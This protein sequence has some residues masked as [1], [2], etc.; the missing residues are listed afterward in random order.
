VTT[1]VREFVKFSMPSL[2]D[3]VAG[4]AQLFAYGNV[5]SVIYALLHGLT[6]TRP[7]DAVAKDDIG[8]GEVCE[9]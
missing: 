5:F 3:G 4:L 6:K 9:K 2:D 1:L 8:Y 7:S